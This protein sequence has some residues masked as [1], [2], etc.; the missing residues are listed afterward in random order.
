MEGTLSSFDAQRLRE[1]H[2]AD[3]IC[4]HTLECINA[5]SADDCMYNHKIEFDY[6]ILL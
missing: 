2:Y 5:K 3:R 4:I 6:S 1:K